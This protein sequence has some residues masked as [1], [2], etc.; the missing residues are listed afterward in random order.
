MAWIKWDDLCLLKR[1]EGLG[2]KDFCSFNIALISK[3]VWRFMNEEDSLWKRVI[4]SRHGEPPWFRGGA[5][6]ARQG[7]MSS[8]WWR[9]VTTSMEDDEGKWLWDNLARKV[10]DGRDT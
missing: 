4:I 1:E 7:T 8:G 5:R 2:F 3:S 9:K 6:G 10:G